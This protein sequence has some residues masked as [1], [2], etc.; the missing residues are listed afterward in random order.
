[1][2]L[3]VPQENGEWLNIDDEIERIAGGG[4]GSQTGHQEMFGTAV[5]IAA[6]EFARLTWDTD[7]G[8]DSLL[9][10]TTPAHPTV[11]ASGVYVV[12]V[13]VEVTGTLAVNDYFEVMVQFDRTGFNASQSQTSPSVTVANLSNA[14]RVTTGFAWY[15][16]LGG[17]IE[18]GVTHHPADGVTAGGYTLFGAHVQRVA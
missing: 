15:V 17:L 11:L 7:D 4:G 3:R 10:L 13:E 6:E 9:D 2:P 18:V 5:T 12:S 1:M 16:P 8:P 14:I